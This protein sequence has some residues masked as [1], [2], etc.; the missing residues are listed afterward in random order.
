MFKASKF[1]DDNTKIVFTSA[2]GSPWFS[3]HTY[4]EDVL[5]AKKNNAHQ[6]FHV[7]KNGDYKNEIKPFIK[8]VKNGGSAR[9]LF[10][11]GGPGYTP[12]MSILGLMEFTAKIPNNEV[13][14]NIRDVALKGLVNQIIGDK[15]HI[16]NAI[17][18]A[19]LSSPIQELLRKATDQQ[20]A[21][22]G[23]S[24]AAPAEQVLAFRAWCAVAAL[25]LTFDPRCRC[26]SPRTARPWR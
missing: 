25:A 13:A 23:A 6:M 3:V 15:K 9:E 24:I 16:E 26:L 20:R 2:D 10:D 19:T 7:V 4:S 22:G 8:Y 1:V 14:K 17:A 18:N 11:E 21:S 5:K 12:V